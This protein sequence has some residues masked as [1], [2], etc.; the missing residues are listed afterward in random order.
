MDTGI[1]TNWSKAPPRFPWV[2]LPILLFCIGAKL[3]HSGMSPLAQNAMLEMGGV[4]PDQLTQ[5]L[6]QAGG[7][8]TDHQILT[9]FSA[10]FIHASW[11][12]LLANMVYLWVF[13]LPLERRLGGLGM[14]VVFVLG[15]ALANLSVVM[16]LPE[17]S[18]PVIGASGA[19]SASTYAA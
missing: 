3:L 16:R 10:L 4:L 13:G 14:V 15:G 19:V 17:L 1:V 12:H 7:G 2:T 8:W 11:L 6:H 9:L 5:I 18:S